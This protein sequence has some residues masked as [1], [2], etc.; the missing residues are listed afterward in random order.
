MCLLRSGIAERLAFSEATKLTALRLER[1]E[2]FISTHSTLP[3]SVGGVE[4]ARSSRDSELQAIGNEYARH[5]GFVSNLNSSAGPRKRT[6]WLGT[7]EEKK[8]KAAASRE[9]KQQRAVAQLESAAAVAQAELQLLPAPQHAEQPVPAEA[10]S[11]VA[12]KPG[13]GKLPASKP[14]ATKLQPWPVRQPTEPGLAASAA[15]IGV[16]IYP[17]VEKGLRH[18]TSA[19][20]ANRLVGN[21]FSQIIL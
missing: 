16:H 12:T 20:G 6:R 11:A 2:D 5:Q 19:A 1:A 4:A 10:A 18:L 14:S 15:A 3:T 7:K 8:A 21:A 17:E 13:A 9:R